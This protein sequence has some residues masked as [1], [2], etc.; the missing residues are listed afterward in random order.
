MKSRDLGITFP[1]ARLKRYLKNKSPKLRVA[2]STPIYLASVIE[3]LVAEV[4][5]LAGSAAKDNNRQ[6]I[7]PRHIQLAVRNDEELNKLLKTITI[8]G[9]GVIPGIHSALLPQKSG[10]KNLES[11]EF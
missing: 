2:A 1:A 10:K 7:T 5:E 4:L 6:R 3:Y 8:S 9:G 11:Q